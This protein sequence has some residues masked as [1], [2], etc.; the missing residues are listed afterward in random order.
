MGVRKS[1]TRL[2]PAERDNYLK[3]VLTLKNTIANPLAPAAQQISLYDQFVVLH[4]Y[5]F[6]IQTPGGPIV[7][8]GHQDAGFGPWHRYYLLR[9]E[10]ALQAVDATV[11]LPYWDW[12]DHA[13]TENIIFQDNY[14][15]PNGGP[16]GIGGGDVESGYF[17][18]AA[19]GVLPPWWPAG[20]A[21]WAIRTGLQEIW[22]ATL[23]RFLGNVASLATQAD[24]DN[25]LLKTDYEA[26]GQFRPTLEASARMHNSVHN[27]VGGHM[28]GGASP[29][30]PIFF[31]HHCNVDRLWAMWQIDGHQGA[32]FYPAAGRTEGHNLNDPMWPWVGALAGYGPANPV[33]DLVLPDFTADPVIHPAD[34][35]DH[36]ALGYAYDSEPVIALA[37]DQTGSMT[38]LTPDPMTG[39]GNVPKWDAAKSGV[40]YF[41]FDCEAAY[42]ARE[43]YVTAG[44]QTFRRLGANTFTK[45]FPAPG[46]GLIKNGGATSQAA[47]DA[48][49]AGEVPGGSTPL[50]D[51]LSDTETTLVRAPFANMPPN[52]QRYLAMLTDGKNTSGAP[53]ASIAAG[54][55]ADT[56]IFAMGFGVGGGWDGVDY[57][58]IADITSKGKTLAGV[59]QTIHGENAGEIDKFYTNSVAAAIGYTPALD[60]VFELFPGEHLHLVFW[61]TEAER[62]FMITALGFDFEDKNWEFCLL[63]P[64]GAE[65]CKTGHSHAGGHEHAGHSHGG[66][67]VC[68]TKATMKK[69]RGR[70][71]IFVHRNGAE[72]KRWAGPWALQAFYK[73]DPKVHIMY[74][75]T[76]ADLL[77]PAGAPPVRGPLYAKLLQSPDQ[78]RPVRSLASAAPHHLAGPRVA[79]QGGAKGAP[80]SLAVNI[81]HN[82]PLKTQ[83]TPAGKPRFAGDALTIDLDVAGVKVEAINIAARLLAPAYSLG[84]LFADTQTITREERKKYVIRDDSGARFDEAAFLAEYERRKPGS[85]RIRDEHVVFKKVGKKHRAKIGKNMHPGVYRVIAYVD[86]SADVTG[87]MAE[88]PCCQGGP[89]RFTRVVEISIPLGIKPD[90]QKSRIQVDW[91]QRGKLVVTATVRDKLGNIAVSGST[92]LAVL[93]NGKE[94]VTAPDLDFTGDHALE[95]EIEGD[96]K[97]EKGI[98][99]RGTLS[100]PL[101]T[102][103]TL[104]LRERDRVKVDVRAGSTVLKAL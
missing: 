5:V 60:P 45:I 38:G 66:G 98:I 99:T 20:L 83:L 41:F 50:A 55:F 92:G 26:F 95:V 71:T 18:A 56:A 78:R 51:A 11:T 4:L 13:G 81:Y 100:V 33:P 28:G 49:V 24:M 70:C 57:A 23:R 40:S 19:P 59:T 86:G 17:A 88:E 102:G 34:V 73:P 77:T 32:A 39:V 31:M 46:F 7:N 103:E 12:T 48:A 65:C 44:V 35:L 8:M 15:G 2:T 84:N 9:Y 21:G 22:G 14:M 37:L 79:L 89:Q 87:K 47:F 54:Q 96:F 36:R 104:R 6:S 62:S 68:P 75:A 91:N 63:D 72:Q 25:V 85:L 82:T 10:Q 67:D 76:G 29:N 97:I 1:A 3:A 61:V 53:L 16:G 90:E 58:T 93:V 69:G 101:V 42:D 30:D 94:A 27:W 64:L 43:A 52:E 74:M 80:C